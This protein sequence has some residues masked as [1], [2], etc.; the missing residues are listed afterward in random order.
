ML[1]HLAKLAS[2]IPHAPKSSAGMFDEYGAIKLDSTPLA[3]SIPLDMNTMSMRET[4]ESYFRNEEFKRRL[5]A[6]GLETYEDSLDFGDEDDPDHPGS[7]YSVEDE[8]DIFEANQRI[9]EAQK[10]REAGSEPAPEPLGGVGGLPPTPSPSPSPGA[11]D[12][13]AATPGNQAPQ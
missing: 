12:A 6:Q 11:P 13:P 10:A 9:R 8:R 1:K 3:E 5:D 7:P 2:L 4:L